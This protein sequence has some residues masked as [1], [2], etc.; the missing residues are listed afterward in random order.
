MKPSWNTHGNL[1]VPVIGILRWDGSGITLSQLEALPGNST[2]PDTF[3]FPVMYR[4]VPGANFGTVVKCPDPDVLAASI[5]A[6]RDFLSRQ[7]Y[8]A[9][10]KSQAYEDVHSE[11]KIT[12]VVTERDR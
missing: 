1:R 3:S 12:Q 4:K 8:D 7:Y 11:N 5:L 9:L 2:N 6:A 10:D